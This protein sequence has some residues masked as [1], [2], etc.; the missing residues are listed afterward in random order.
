MAP[1]IFRQEKYNHTVDI[2][3]LGLTLY[4]LLNDGFPPFSDPRFNS[5]GMD[6]HQRRLSGEPFPDP[7]FGNAELSAILRKACAFDPRNRYQSAQQMQTALKQW[8]DKER[9]GE[10]KLLST[11]LS[12][13]ARG[14]FFSG[15]LSSST[16]RTGGRR[17]GSAVAFAGRESPLHMKAIAGN[18]P[19][20]HTAVP[21]NFPK[22]SAPPLPPLVAK[23]PRRRSVAAVILPVLLL[24]LAGILLWT[25][26]D[27]LFPGNTSAR[28]DLTGSASFY[29]H[30]AEAEVYYRD[31]YISGDDN[32][33]YRK[34][35]DDRLYIYKYQGNEETVTVPAEL[36]GFTV[37]GIEERAFSGQP[38]R[39]V[40]LPDTLSVIQAEAF[41]NCNNLTDINI[42]AG[43]RYIGRHA[44]YNT[45]WLNN[46]PQEFVIVGNGCLIRCNR[47][48]THLVIPDEVRFFGADLANTNI[49][50][51]TFG[52]KSELEEIGDL[53]F[54]GCTQ[55]QLDALPDNLKRIGEKAFSGCNSLI[56]IRLPSEI[57]HIGFKAFIPESGN[58]SGTLIRFAGSETDWNSVEGTEGLNAVF[59]AQ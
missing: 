58:Q 38:V 50:S 33:I 1:E 30:M 13:P 9:T 17:P 6:A 22:Q 52:E 3:A 25:F 26:K 48:A 27:R 53:S 16:Q 37:I 32:F 34:A 57:K 36:D 49:Q 46:R 43:V 23:K 24:V 47:E 14:T 44:F 41:S 54:Y 45:P 18:N 55:L 4:R 5:S 12:M 28:T 31:L 39:K 42:P 7:R 20:G 8:L 15:S 56:S 10:R 11:C 59:N 35:D 51:L 40:E 2:Y 21:R 29:R 19:A